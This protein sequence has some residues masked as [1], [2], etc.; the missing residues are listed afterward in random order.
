MIEQFK[1]SAKE[2]LLNKR[3]TVAKEDPTEELIELHFE[4]Q[5]FE[6]QFKE[7]VDISAFLVQKNRELDDQL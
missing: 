7:L 1:E 4:I 3:A 5:E 6:K 2:S